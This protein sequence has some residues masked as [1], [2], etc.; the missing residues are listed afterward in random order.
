VNPLPDSRNFK[1]KKEVDLT[2]MFTKE[3]DSTTG[4]VEF[5]Q[6]FEETMKIVW[7]LK[8]HCPQDLEMF[9]DEELEEFTPSSPPHRMATCA[10]PIYVI[11]NNDDDK[12]LLLLGYE[13]FLFSVLLLS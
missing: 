13:S 6:K 2:T 11:P 12:E 5:W 10:P 4:E 3:L 1:L 9:F 8:H 7:K